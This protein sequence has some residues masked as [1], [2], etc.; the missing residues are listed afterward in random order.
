[1]TI[2]TESWAQ[3]IFCTFAFNGNS[4]A[5]HV[6][7]KTLVVSTGKWNAA[8]EVRVEDVSTVRHLESI[9]EEWINMSYQINRKGFP[10]GFLQ[11]FERV[12]YTFL[13]GFNLLKPGF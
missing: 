1:M 9:V 4:S 3:R 6:K 11:S 8:S 2:T 12:S 5:F 10:K 13:K 7:S